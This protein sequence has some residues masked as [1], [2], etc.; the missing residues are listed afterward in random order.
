MSGDIRLLKI[1]VLAAGLALTLCGPVELHSQLYSSVESALRDC[2]GDSLKWDRVIWTNDLLEGLVQ[3]AVNDSDT[4]C[5]RLLLNRAIS[6]LQEENT[7]LE[8]ILEALRISPHLQKYFPQWTVKDPR[9]QIETLWALGIP[10]LIPQVVDSA[11]YALWIVQ[12]PLKGQEGAESELLELVIANQVDTVMLVQK[13]RLKPTLGLDLYSRLQSRD[14]PHDFLASPL[15]QVWNNYASVGLSMLGGEAL[16]H[17]ARAVM[18]LRL[19]LGRET[20]G[21]PFYYGAIWNLFAVYRP[22]EAHSG[23]HSDTYELGLQIPFHPGEKPVGLFGP[24]TFKQR[25]INGAH[26]IAGKFQKRIAERG[27]LLGEFSIATLTN[28]GNG[29]LI[30][31]DGAVVESDTGKTFSYLSGNLHLYY[32]MRLDPLGLVGV[33]V[34][35]GFGYYEM[36]HAKLGTDGIKVR[37]AGHFDRLDFYSNMSYRHLGRVEY[38]LTLQYFDFTLLGSA[39]LRLFDWLSLEAKYAS[40]I[41]RDARPWEHRNLLAISPKLAFTFSF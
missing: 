25:R 6:D 23:R 26:G 39:Y 8:F 38:G 31:W 29:P 11:K 14:Y 4:S 7:R 37:K 20:V 34:G 30:D 24:A 21:Y 17:S 15:S 35:A 27:S 41:I 9:Y 33:T 13:G 3:H 10:S 5:L 36:R 19:E 1:Y 32:S 28:R 40:I 12:D 18:G 16:V 2:K 22:Q